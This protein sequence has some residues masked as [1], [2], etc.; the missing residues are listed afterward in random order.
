MLA[1]YKCMI[2]IIAMIQNKDKYAPEY[3]PEG[4]VC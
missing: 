3:S 2:I 4:I 1:L